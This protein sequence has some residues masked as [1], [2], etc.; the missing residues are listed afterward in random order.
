VFVLAYGDFGLPDH[1]AHWDGTAWT[2]YVNATDTEL[3]AL[4]GAG[5]HVWAADYGGSVVRYRP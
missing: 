1:V 4:G 5:D 2:T 3:S